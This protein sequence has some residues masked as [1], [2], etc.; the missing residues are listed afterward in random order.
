MI[1][2]ART[3]ARSPGSGGGGLPARERNMSEDTIR[4]LEGVQLFQGLSKDQLREL[5]SVGQRSAYPAGGA[6]FSQGDPAHGFYVILS[7]R[8]KVYKLSPEGRE[9]ILH[10][11]GSGEPIGEVPVFAGEAFPAHAETLEPSE[12]WFLPRDRLRDLFARDPSLALNMLAILSK[13]LRRFTDLIEDLSLKEIPARLAAYLMQ[14]QD[15]Q[16]G[17]STI[18]L[19]V[20]KGVLAKILGTSQETLSRVLRRMT[21]AGILEV[22]Q[23]KITIHND[24]M[25]EDLAE[26]YTGLD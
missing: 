5:E 17:G 9:Q 10:I 13:R 23:K 3:P 15:S 18:S 19:D 12:L 6:I 16:G 11:F 21:E 4:N 24:G 25:L 14:L 8:V 7:G 20:S 26:G 1:D 22:R 2:P